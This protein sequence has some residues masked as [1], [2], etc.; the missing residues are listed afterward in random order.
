MIP[1]LQWFLELFTTR[2]Y[3]LYGHKNNTDVRSVMAGHVTQCVCVNVYSARAPG[4]L[5]VVSRQ[6]PPFSIFF[7][8][9]ICPDKCAS[10]KK[11]IWL[12]MI[13]YHTH[14]IIRSKQY[15]AILTS[16]KTIHTTRELILWLIA[17]QPVNTLQQS[18]ALTLILII[19]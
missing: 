9:N 7:I 12:M 16:A 2:K 5:V 11:L 6:R 3:I 15:V 4:A 18:C 14:N 10:L 1:R 17:Q 19:R 8:L 13:L